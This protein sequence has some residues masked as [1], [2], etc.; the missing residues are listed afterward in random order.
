MKKILAALCLLFSLSAHA[1][2]IQSATLK[3][4]GLTCSMCS[5]AVY[6]ALSKVAFV[7]EVQASIRESS[8][9][10]RFKKDAA[11]NLDA[12]KNAVE[13][14]GFSVAQ[15]LVTVDFSGEA[16]ENDTHLEQ[17]SNTWHFVN[18]K[19]Q[20][21]TGL[22]TLTVIDKHFVPAK[23]FKKYRALTGMSCYDTGYMQ[24]C[25]SKSRKGRIY[26]VTLPASV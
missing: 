16:I 2:N 17:G 19:P 11:V 14:A 12:I 4:S 22:Q 18:V 7:Q 21:L 1:G 26:H 9:T 3:A 23:D 25:C 20:K 6:T 15:L 13:D 10:L 24:S 8:Y 5:K